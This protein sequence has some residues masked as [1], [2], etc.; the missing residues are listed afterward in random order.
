ME[1]KSIY[2]ESF[3]KYGCIIHDNF[4]DVLSKLVKI[5]KPAKGVKYLASEETLES[6]S[7]KEKLENVY[8]GGMPIQVGYCVGFNKT[9]NALE[10]HKNSEINMANEDFILVLGLRQDI[11][12]NTYDIGKAEAFLV[13]SKVAVEIY[14]TTLHYCPISKDETPFNMLVVLPKGT[15]VGKRK[16]MVDPLLYC[17]NKW[18]LTFEGTGEAKNGAYAGLKG[19]KPWMK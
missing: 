15:N 6:S 7:D 16:S 8:F 10:Y 11:I 5:E 9:V 3:K 14:A 2:D 13:P 19:E 12:D 18:L 1:I 4:D 17:T